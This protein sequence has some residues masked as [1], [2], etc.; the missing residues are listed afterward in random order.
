MF[1]VSGV[2]SHTSWVFELAGTAALAPNGSYLY[3]IYIYVRTC[4]CVCVFEYVFIEPSSIK[5]VIG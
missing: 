3:I 1:L 2:E 5:N 4:V